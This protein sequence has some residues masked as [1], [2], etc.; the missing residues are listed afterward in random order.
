MIWIS[1]EPYITPVEGMNAY[2]NK[3]TCKYTYICICDLCLS[4]NLENYCSLEKSDVIRGLF[5]IIII[6]VV[7]VV[8]MFHS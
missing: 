8:V 5:I 2:L 7:V 4:V 3:Y 1:T 6:V